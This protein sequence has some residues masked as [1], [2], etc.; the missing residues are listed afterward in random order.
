MRTSLKLLLCTALTGFGMVDTALAQSA[1][2]PATTAGAVDIV[3]TANRREQRLQDVP[4]A[5]SAISSD[6]LR[7]QNINSLLD[8]GTGRIPGLTLV[9]LFGNPAA[10]IIT[11]RGQ[12]PGDAS[13]GTKDMPVA[14]YVD[15][16]NFPRSQGLALDL[17]TPERI[18]V[19]RGPQGQLFGRNAEGGVVQVVTR[20]PTGVLHGDFKATGAE[21]GT[22]AVK[23]MLDLPEIAGFRVQLSAF[24]RNH[25][26]YVHNVANPLLENITVFS[27][28]LGHIRGGT[29]SFDGDLGAVKS[30]GERIA[31]VREF[32]KLNVF[33]TFDNSWVRESQGYT[34]YTISPNCGSLANPT[35]VNCPNSSNYVAK[36]FTSN[37]VFQQSALG[38]SNPRTTDSSIFAP[39]MYTKSSGHMLNLT[40]PLDGGITLK[41][42]TGYRHVNRSGYNSSNLAVSSA[43]PVSGEYLDSKAFSQELQAQYSR[44]GLNITVG[45]IYFNEK[46]IDERDNLIGTNCGSLGATLIAQCTPVGAPNRN[47]YYAILAVGP[48]AGNPNVGFRAQSS[49]TNAYAAYGQATWTPPVLDDKLELTAGLRYSNDTKKG[50]RTILGGVVLPAPILNESKTDRVDP[51]FT[52]KFNLTPTV[53]VYARYASGF[54]DGGA[55]VR[56][57]TFNAFDAETVNSFEIGFKSQFFDRRVTLNLAGFHNEIK[58]QQ[59][60]LQPNPQNPGITD[61]INIPLKTKIEGIEAELTVKPTDRLTL[62][63]SG[64]YLKKDDA[65]LVGIETATLKGFVPTATFSDVTGVIPDAATLLA[66][67]N[68]VIY[69]LAPYSAP[70]WS[71]FFAADYTVPVGSSSIQF[72]AEWTKTST[73]FTSGNRYN[74]PIINGVATPKPNYNSGVA[75]D[76]VNAKVTFRDIGVGALKL[77]F[78]VFADNLLDHVDKA[79]VYTAGNAINVATPAAQSPALL[80]PPR[81]IGAEVRVH[82]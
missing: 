17:V 66:H 41:S 19:L 64:T 30:N 47:P 38:D 22:V 1:D 40:L 79:F 26:G 65:I 74:T 51:A 23:G 15:G 68:S 59:L 54:R 16:I 20:R 71:G 14:F 8:V 60:D 25:D 62:T 13:Q 21:W 50:S 9:P 46:V 32:G 2:Q 67:P 45:A 57:N 7:N 42:I 63:V 78:A 48:A 5:V 3:V 11:M 49:R 27:N 18:E 80:M 12:G 58:N 70:R 77:D 34:A 6:S 4:L 24:M 28:P 37:G 53:N 35:A 75:R 81:T 55:N 52:I 10:V 36:A 76:R 82:F 61:S 73:W 39:Y 29:G 69:V 56:S 72:H 33:Y 44:P 43:Y 31:V